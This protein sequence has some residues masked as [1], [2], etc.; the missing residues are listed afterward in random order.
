MH[1]IVMLDLII[2]MLGLIVMLGFIKVATKT[3]LCLVYLGCPW[4]PT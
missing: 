2:V 3:L 1:L 4:S